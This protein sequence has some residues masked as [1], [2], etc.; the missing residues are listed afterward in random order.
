[1]SRGGRSGCTHEPAPSYN[2]PT[3]FQMI[4]RANTLD[5]NV[6]NKLNEIRQRQLESENNSQAHEPSTAA[7]DMPLKF[8]ALGGVV[9]GLIIAWLINSFL[10]TENADQIA[11]RSSVAIHENKIREAN[12]TIE[13]LNDRVELLTESISGL[14]AELTQAMGL[15]KLNNKIEKP[16]IA[17]QSKFETVDEKPVY[18]PADPQASVLADGAATSDKAFKPTHAVRTRLNLRTSTSPDDAP[19][20]VLSAGTEVRYIN[21]ENGWYYVDTEQF[22]KG[23]CASEFLSP[24]SSP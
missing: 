24:L 21:E 19:I 23:W 15:V 13:Q 10:P 9:A 20:G 16:T 22:G 7:S 18:N 17:D 5:Q 2:H 14:E 1:M 12:E 4:S 8:A 6:R 3:Y 11:Q